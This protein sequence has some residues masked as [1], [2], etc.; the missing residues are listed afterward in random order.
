M[1]E[2]RQEN[3]V[4]IKHVFM[5]LRGKVEYGMR[6]IGYG[7]DKLEGYTDSNWAVSATIRKNTLWCFFSLGSTMIFC[8][9]K[10]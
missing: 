3:L 8:F 6:Y 9:S 1:V 5:Y 4:E 10:K 7:E 2:P